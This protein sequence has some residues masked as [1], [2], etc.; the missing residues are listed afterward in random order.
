MGEL[1]GSQIMELDSLQQNQLHKLVITVVDTHSEQHLSIGTTGLPESDPVLALGRA[2]AEV[3]REMAQC[4]AEI[5]CADAPP[6]PLLGLTTSGKELKNRLEPPVDCTTIRRRRNRS[7]AT[8]CRRMPP[9]IFHL[10]WRQ[11]CTPA[12][13]ALPSTPTD[14]VDSRAAV[15]GRAGRY[16]GR[17]SGK[18]WMQCLTA[19]TPMH[20]HTWPTNFRSLCM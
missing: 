17:L 8:R 11:V 1:S 14:A 3:M 9:P 15:Q 16:R 20:F 2:A 10:P 13:P 4:T 12:W 5:S 7:R 6:T 18:G 19:C